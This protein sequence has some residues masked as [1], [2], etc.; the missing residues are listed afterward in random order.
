MHC[1]TLWQWRLQRPLHASPPSN[2]LSGFYAR[3]A[4]GGAPLRCNQQAPSWPHSQPM[5]MACDGDGPA[6]PAPPAMAASGKRG[7]GKGRG[8]TGGQCPVRGVPSCWRCLE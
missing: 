5:P 7:L 3:P 8:S 4:S 6:E 1:V 2:F